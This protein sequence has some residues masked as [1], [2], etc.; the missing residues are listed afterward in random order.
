MPLSLFKNKN[1]FVNEL[2]EFFEKSNP[3]RG[4]WNPGSY[5]WHG[6]EPDIHTAYLFNS[7]GRPD[8]TQK[9]V[10]WTLDNKYGA[11]YDG[12]DGDDD[13]GTLSAW[14]VFSSL[15]FYPVAGSDVYQ[16]GAPLF[17]KA[18]LNIGE[19]KLNIAADNFSPQNIYVRNVWLNGEFFP[20]PQ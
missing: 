7:A 1:Y 20:R 12:L 19:N 14:Y 8:L 11:D 5:Y 10:R 16:I 4:H 18:E 2:N 9:W 13:A 15:G 17:P 3:K 6:N